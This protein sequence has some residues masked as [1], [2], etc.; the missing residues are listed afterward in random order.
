MNVAAVLE[1]LDD[2]DYV[3]DVS[4]QNLGYDLEALLKNG[5]RRYYEVKSVNKLGELISITNNEYSTA[6]QYKENYY[7]AIANQSDVS[8]DI[9][10]IKNPINSLF[11]S[12]R[13]TRWEWICDEYE[14]EV[15][16]T[17]LG[18]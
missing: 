3:V 14:G 18:N 13:V 9:C 5:K 15:I 17:N 8:I 2:I 12:K 10:F 4:T 11:L 16:T 1:L 7:L 6:S